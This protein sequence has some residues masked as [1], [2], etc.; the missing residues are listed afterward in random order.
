MVHMKTLRNINYFLKCSYESTAGHLPKHLC[1]GSPNS[2]GFTLIELTVV[3]IIVMILVT[4]AIP[5]YTNMKKATKITRAKAEIRVVEKAIFAF[6]TDRGSLPNQLS[7]IPGSE[8]RLLDPW[9]HPYQYYNIATGTGSTA[10]R[11]TSYYPEPNLNDDFDLYSMGQ[12]GQTANNIVDPS[13]G[14]NFSSDDI[15]RTG[16]GGSV[17]LGSEF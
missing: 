2:R 13:L 11:Y 17:E 15:V 8:G 16:D 14:T 12:D 1:L 5:A 7:D 9:N 3:L 10:V 4:C 6:Y